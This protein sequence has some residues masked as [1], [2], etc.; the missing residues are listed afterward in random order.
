MSCWRCDDTGQCVTRT[1]PYEFTYQG[2]TIH[3]TRT[4]V[5][6]CGVCERG[7][8]IAAARLRKGILG[9]RQTQEPAA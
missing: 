5:S 2:R 8:R 7:Q 1:E 9:D 3:K 6:P 4:Y